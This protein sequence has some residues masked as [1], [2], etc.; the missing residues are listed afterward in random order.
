MAAAV[1]D[2]H[3]IGSFCAV[4]R[5]HHGID[6]CWSAQ[7]VPRSSDPGTSCRDITSTSGGCLCVVALISTQYGR[8][9]RELMDNNFLAADN[10]KQILRQRCAGITAVD[11][12]S[13]CANSLIG[14][15]LMRSWK[16]KERET[17]PCRSALRACLSH[18]HL[19]SSAL[20]FLEHEFLA[21]A[22]LLA[23]VMLPDSVDGMSA[24]DLGTFAYGLAHKVMCTIKSA[25][26]FRADPLGTHRVSELVAAWKLTPN[27]HKNV[28][29]WPAIPLV[30][31]ALLHGRLLADMTA[32]VPRNT[33]RTWQPGCMPSRRSRQGLMGTPG[34]I[35]EHLAYMET[36]QASAAHP[37]RKRQKQR[38]V[39]EDLLNAIECGAELKDQNRFEASALK[40]LKFFYPHDWADRK[41]A[42]VAS[43]KV[44]PKRS[45]MR[46]GRVRLDVAAMLSHRKLVRKKQF[47]RYVSVDASPQLQRSYEALVTAERIV[48]KTD[49]E[50][51][52]FHEVTPFCCITRILPLATLGQG[53]TA[54]SD[55]AVAHIHQ[56]WC[57]Y[58]PERSAVRTACSN[59][60]QVLSDMGVEFGI[61]NY[62][63]VIND[64]IPAFSTDKHQLSQRGF[65]YP[66]ALQVPG[67]LHILDWVVRETVESF[68]F[69]PT[70]QAKAKRI[71]QYTHSANHRG[72]L[73]QI[74]SDHNA[75]GTEAATMTHSL[76]TSTGRFAKWRWKTLSQA[77][78]DLSRV[79]SA[80]RFVAG[81]CSEFQK[82][83]SIRDS[84]AAAALHVACSDSKT[85]NQAHVVSWVIEPLMNFMKWVQGCACH[86]DQLLRGEEVHCSMKGC[87]A[88]ELGQ[89]LRACLDELQDY[90]QRFRCGMFFPEVDT[91]EVKSALTKAMVCLSTKLHWV[92]ELPYLV[93]QVLHKSV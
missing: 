58:G 68:N 55:K 89:R 91:M 69:W 86:E 64:C 52:T 79:E 60:R 62:V 30:I 27:V 70:W 63:D 83:L 92:N 87:R 23:P 53:R 34:A 32:V 8:W 47:Y 50:N 90:R 43:G 41:Q 80:F 25:S 3:P 44:M 13:A 82:S 61:A 28:F 67:L 42:L 26:E 21:T 74:I 36:H 45:T 46:L 48:G 35:G 73:R 33:F 17:S 49:I 18:E 39:T 81:C 2:D 38:M 16:L 71:L 20:H 77:T 56:T 37:E 65:L 75:N 78:K 4:Q 88:T 22:E 6:G 59:V 1:E 15:G 72:L 29:A 14:F 12:S 51:K 40:T 31:T 9:Q 76:L 57:E 19:R 85:W 11:M 10:A 5:D 93:W 54:L 66:F 7:R 24:A 84:A